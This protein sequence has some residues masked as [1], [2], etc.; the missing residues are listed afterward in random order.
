MPD[1]QSLNP[2][3]RKN[4]LRPL[5][6]RYYKRQMDTYIGKV[7]DERFKGRDAI[8]PKKARKKTSIDLALEA[9]FKESGQ[10]VDSQFATMDPEFRTSAI[11]NMLILIIAGH[12]TTASTLCYCYHML[13]QNPDKQVRLREELDG[14]FG[15][16]INAAARLRRD[17]YLINK[18]EYMSAVI[19]ET[20]RLWPPGS[21]IRRGTKDQFLKHPDTGELL[22]T[23]G[24]VSIALSCHIENH[25]YHHVAT[26][27]WSTPS[28]HKYM[29][30]L[31]RSFTDDM[32]RHSRYT[33]RS[34][35]LGP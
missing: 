18:C 17:P 5:A 6:F 3:H 4:P 7:L 33:T 32:A 13:S 26:S 35:V 16:G 20:L 1:T 22:P 10:D 29:V 27:S 12:D 31:I 14:V 21:T 34:Q 25:S 28:L 11:D 30:R 9:W 8:L 15:A 24:L 19:K 23:E 2:F